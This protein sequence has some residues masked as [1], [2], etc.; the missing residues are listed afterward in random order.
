MQNAQSKD[1][2]RLAEE[3]QVALTRKDFVAAETRFLEA[4]QSASDT[5]GAESSDLALAVTEL[6]ECYEAQG[7][8][9][10]AEDCYKRVSMILGAAPPV[11]HQ[12]DQEQVIRARLLN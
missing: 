12:A 7:K 10:L 3:G 11:V 9:A 8:E 1:W 2:E 6:A 5:F 4:V